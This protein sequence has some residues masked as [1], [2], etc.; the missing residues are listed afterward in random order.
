M[1]LDTMDIMLFGSLE[2]YFRR[3]NIIRVG[4]SDA[5]ISEQNWGLAARG[6]S[7]SYGFHSDAVPVHARNRTFNRPRRDARIRQRPRC[8]AKTDINIAQ[9]SGKTKTKRENGCDRIRRNIY[10]IVTVQLTAERSVARVQSCL[11]YRVCSCRNLE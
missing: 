10:N 5:C 2:Y 3:P 4:F 6:H 1:K 8:V 11:L 7:S 9:S